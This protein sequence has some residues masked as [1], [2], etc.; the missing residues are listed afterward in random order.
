[1]PMSPRLLRPRATG[2]NARS[3]ANLVLWLDANDTST[4]T[5]ET[6]VKV[7]ADKSGGGKNFTQDT[8]NSQPAYTA[9]LNG[10]R[11]V[12]F[13]GSSNQLNN[14]TNIINNANMTMF[15][16]GQRSSGSFGGYITSIDSVFS[17]DVSPAVLINSTN[18][19]VRGDSGTLA[20]ASGGFTGPAV[21]TGVVTNWAPSLF[22]AGAFVQSQAAGG[23]PGA[24]NV[25]TAIGT[26]RIAAA[27]FLN[28]YIAEIICYTRVLSTSER[29]TV[30][31]YLGRKWGLTVA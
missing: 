29:Q 30:E 24:L 13:N 1:M 26:Y 25:R 16:V 21:I 22:V 31:R 5:V 12:S 9:T 6:G 10:K 27:N 14:A 28:G 20:S 11:V 18:I 17:G 2:F 23:T 19:A 3:I 8:L 7:W 15:V 4:V